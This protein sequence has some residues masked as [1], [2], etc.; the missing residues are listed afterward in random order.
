MKIRLL[1][2]LHL[3]MNSYQYEFIGEDVLVLAGD[4][5]N[6]GRHYQILD[7][8]PG[9]VQTLMVAGNHEYYHGEF[10]E[11]NARLKALEAGY[12]NFTFLN[13]ESTTLNGI[14]VFGGTMYTDFMLYPNPFIGEENA[15][16]QIADFRLSSILDAEGDE[17]RWTVD[18]HKKA[19]R[20]FKAAFL[21]WLE[22]TKDAEKKLVITHF[23]PT[24]RVTHPRW[25]TVDNKDLNPYFVCD[26][27]EYMGW[28]GLWVYGHTHDNGET[29]IGETR[30]C[31]NPYGYRNGRENPHFNN[32]LLLDI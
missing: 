28:K 30:V 21:P 10:H 20:K 2:D 1:S 3:E 11:V 13:N 15:M 25:L 9:S 6:C 19:H 12:P 7:R 32:N 5:H 27:T 8:I 4:I 17:R 31:G 29:V 16:R 26:M 22:E 14:P 18:D 24:L 23:V